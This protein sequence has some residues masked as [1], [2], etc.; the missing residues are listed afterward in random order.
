[1]SYETIKTQL[2]LKHP[3]YGI[4]RVCLDDPAQTKV[5]GCVYTVF[6][7]FTDC[8]YITQNSVGCKGANTGCGFC[9]DMP[10]IPGGFGNFIANGGGEGCPPGER[11][12]CSADVAEKMFFAQPK[13]VMEGK[14]AIKI[15]V[16]TENST[17]ELVLFFATPDQLSGLVHLFYYR[18]DDY[19]GIIVPVCSGC[20]QL[21]RLPFFEYDNNTGKGVVGNMDFFSRPHL[22][23][24]L[25]AFTVPYLTFK[26]MCEDAPNCCFFA[27]AWSGVK[28]RL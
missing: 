12:K 14:N 8:I 2:K 21:F 23:K 6:K 16:L 9:D 15:E 19:D 13:K 24:D 10:N 17:S 3:A 27:P 28:K 20:A 4:S 22:D 18:R 26:Q 25:L 1:M 7:N 11:I 5:G